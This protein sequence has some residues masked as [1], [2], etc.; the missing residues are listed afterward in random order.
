[1]DPDIKLNKLLDVVEI[2]SVDIDV[3]Y[4]GSEN[5]HAIEL[6]DAMHREIDPDAV[7]KRVFQTL[8]LGVDANVE[9]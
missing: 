4:R 9:N 7:E 6:P 8:L 5:N 1:M 2:P 3:V